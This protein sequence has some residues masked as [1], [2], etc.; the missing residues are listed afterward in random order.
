MKRTQRR[1]HLPVVQRGDQI[2]PTPYPEPTG[3]IHPNYR[4]WSWFRPNNW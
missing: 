4:H 3:H 1:E 2:E